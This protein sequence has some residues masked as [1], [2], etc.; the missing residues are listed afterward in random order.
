MIPE[1]LVAA[2]TAFEGPARLG[3]CEVGPAAEEDGGVAS[4]AGLVRD[5][6]FGGAE[7]AREDGDE[8]GGRDLGREEEGAGEARWKRSTAWRRTV[9]AE[10]GRKC[11]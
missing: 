8:A 11:D 9:V 5:T 3:G 10:G 2:L 4:P 1:R 7:N 6:G